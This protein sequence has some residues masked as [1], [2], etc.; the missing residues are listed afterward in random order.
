MKMD[1]ETRAVRGSAPCPP[2]TKSAKILADFV[3]IAGCP[4]VKSGA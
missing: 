4:G 1:N 2:S 3:D